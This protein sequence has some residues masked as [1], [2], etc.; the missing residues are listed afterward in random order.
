MRGVFGGRTR[1]NCRQFASLVYGQLQTRYGWQRKRRVVVIAIV[2]GA[3]AGFVVT[4][5]HNGTANVMA[6]GMFVSTVVG[7]IL[8]WTLSGKQLRQAKL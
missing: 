2:I 7:V 3:G 6:G 1:F 8:L 5:L 4:S